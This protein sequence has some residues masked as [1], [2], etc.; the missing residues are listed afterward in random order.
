MS[1][2]TFFAS[3]CKVSCSMAT[4]DENSKIVGSNSLISEVFAKFRRYC[5]LTTIKKAIEYLQ[6]TDDSFD[7]INY[8]DTG[9]K[10]H[11]GD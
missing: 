2:Q 5:I 8:T 3:R 9:K 11:C 4:Q 10:N 6:Y 7:T 1:A